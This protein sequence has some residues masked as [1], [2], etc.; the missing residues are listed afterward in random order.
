MRTTRFNIKLLSLLTAVTFSG[1][2]LADV[3]IGISLPVTG[4]GAALGIPIKNSLDFWPDKV[5][6]EK[7]KIVFIDDASDP[8]KSVQNARK[9]ASEDNA[10]L[11][12]GSALTPTALAIAQVTQELSIPQLAMAPVELPADK[13]KWV[14]RLPQPISL[15]AGAVLEDMK[16]RGI[17]TVGFI[18]YS[19]PWGEVWLKEMTPGLEAAGIKLVATERYARADT[20]VTGQALKLLAAKPDAVL[21]AGS[22]AGAA[23]PQTTLVE[24]GYKG[25]FYQTHAA[26]SRDVLR[27]GGAAMEGAILPVGPVLVAEQLPDS[28]PSKKQG[29][30]YVKQYEAKYGAGSRTTFGAH[31]NDALA[32]IL[33]AV[34]VALKKAKPGTQEF[35]NALRDALETEKEMVAANGVYNYTTTDHFGMDKR[36]RVLVKVEKGEFKLMK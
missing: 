1:T 29:V 8:T 3:T 11:I 17:K 23:L 14:F 31:A 25:V 20:S 30:N 15:M 21:V 18:G 35:R 5:G 6:N 26:A 24:K 19:D 10:D 22:G 36:G 2:A 27:V 9:F 7:L 13:Q 34:P 4:P 33:H 32:L 28:H 12:V 16:A